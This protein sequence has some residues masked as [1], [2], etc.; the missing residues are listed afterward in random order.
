M[1]KLAIDAGLP[2]ITVYTD[3]PVN[4]GAVISAIAGK[5]TAPYSPAL[6]TQIKI[7]S[8]TTARIATALIINL[9]TPY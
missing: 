1:L 6:K 9:C 5:P 3:D 7:K 8:C 4:A 2:L